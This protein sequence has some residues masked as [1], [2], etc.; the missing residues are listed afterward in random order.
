MQHVAL[1]WRTWPVPAAAFAALRA[2]LATLGVGVV[3]GEQATRVRTVVVLA[4]AVAAVL[5]HGSWRAPAGWRGR[6]CPFLALSGPATGAS[7][8]CQF[9]ALEFGK[10]A[11]VVPLD[12]RSIVMIADGA[13]PVA[14]G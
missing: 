14:R 2:I 12:V 4:L 8:R 5:V 1:A 6:E 7:C 11:R 9:R 3:P 13:R 10:A